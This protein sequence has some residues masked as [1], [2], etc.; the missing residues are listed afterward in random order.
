MMSNDERWQPIE[1][2]PND[3]RYVIVWPSTWYGRT[4]CARFDED[5]YAKK[6]RPYW[7]RL[8]DNGSINRSRDNPPTH[9]M[10]ILPG[11]I[12]T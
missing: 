12:E 8:D 6:P 1:T 4:S 11:P 3:G 10:P 7:S 5:R 9:W 2:A